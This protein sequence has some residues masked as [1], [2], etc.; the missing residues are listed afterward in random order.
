MSASI[1]PVEFSDHVHGNVQG[2]IGDRNRKWGAISN[3]SRA[4]GT[5]VVEVQVSAGDAAGTHSRRRR[6]SLLEPMSTLTA[7]ENAVNRQIYAASRP[8]YT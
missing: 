3:H 8:G 5:G 2:T 6:G 4:S 1:G 7:S